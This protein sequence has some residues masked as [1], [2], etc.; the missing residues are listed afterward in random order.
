MFTQQHTST[1]PTFGQIRKNQRLRHEFSLFYLDRACLSKKGYV[2]SIQLVSKFNE[3]KDF[4][5]LFSFLKRIDDLKNVDFLVFR[6]SIRPEWEDP[7]NAKGGK[8][9]IKIKKGKNIFFFFFFFE[10]RQQKKNR[11]FFVVTK[12]KKKNQTKH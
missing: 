5:N 6:D 4:W 7:N 11:N 9:T 2:E 8:W 10:N 1:T 3:L 12:H